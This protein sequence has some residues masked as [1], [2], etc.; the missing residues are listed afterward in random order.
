MADELVQQRVAEIL[1]AIAQEAKARPALA[2]VAQE[3]LKRLA[4]ARSNK[5]RKLARLAATYVLAGAGK[6]S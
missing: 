4:K 5:T 3:T 2:R 6:T 1:C